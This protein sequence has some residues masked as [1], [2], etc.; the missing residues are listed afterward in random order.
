[1]R[2][3]HTIIA[4]AILA[5]AS[6]AHA[7]E[8][9]SM[10]SFS[11]FG[12]I[13]ATHASEKNADYNTSQ[14]QPKGAGF[15]DSTT[16][17]NSRLGGQLTATLNDNWSGVIQ[18]ITEQR[19]DN[20][21]KPTLEWANVKYSVNQDLSIR[22]GR[23]ALPGY[24]VSDSRK[25][26]FS[27]TAVRPPVDVYRML[28]LTTNDGVDATYRTKFGSVT[29]TVNAWVGGSEFTFPNGT[30]EGLE[31][32]AN[33]VQGIS[34]NIEVGDLSLR[35]TVIRGKVTFPSV[36]ALRAIPVPMYQAIGMSGDHASY[37]FYQLG[38]MYDTGKWFATG[39]V[40]QTSY[41]LTGGQDAW[42]VQGG[43]RMG[44][45]TPY[46]TYATVS[47]RDNPLL[48]TLKRMDQRTASVG[49][50]YDLLTNT[51]LK[52]QYDNVRATSSNPGTLSNVQPGYKPGTN[53]VI[54][55]AVDFVF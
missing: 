31:G 50:R 27:M 10:F 1:M 34:N 4:S 51:A 6:S 11:G 22:V 53:N 9:Q 54:S 18:V 7:Q 28:S 14:F 52:L 38:A 24:M 13:N 49:V 55:A 40:A 32:R 36:A 17:N 39:E 25:V 21:W 45:F 44:A 41:D 30:Q 48:P 8:N 47:Q 35:A 2:I 26:G 43:Y 3:K 46:A 29:N 23:I 42:Y 20:S 16:F 33:N 12:S 37:K 19:W 5:L 15:S